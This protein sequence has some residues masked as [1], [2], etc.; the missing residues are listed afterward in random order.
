MEKLGCALGDI[1]GR[2]SQRALW[3]CRR[4]GS[5]PG[6]ITGPFFVDLLVRFQS[7]FFVLLFVPLFI[8]FFT[9]FYIFGIRVAGSS[10]W[11]R[12]QEEGTS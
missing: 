9:R 2:C 6:R 5:Q 4:Q 8:L 12:F 7:P 10:G 11:D 3:E 1:G